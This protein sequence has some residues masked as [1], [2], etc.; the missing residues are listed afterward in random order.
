M[1]RKVK[2]FAD[3]SVEKINTLEK[4]LSGA[5][6][7]V[8][9]RTEFVHGVARRIQT[10]PRATLFVDRIANIHIIALLIAGLLSTAVFLAVVG[11]ALV[12]LLGKKNTV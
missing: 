7:P 2:Q 1:N 3:A 4:K 12:S 9:P 11:R 6:R 10:G 8:K 5:L